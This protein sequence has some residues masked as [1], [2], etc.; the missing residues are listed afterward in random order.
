LY[1]SHSKLLLHC[2]ASSHHCKAP[3]PETEKLFVETFDTVL[4]HYFIYIK[5]LTVNPLKLPDIN[6]DTG[7]L[8][9]PGEYE[10]ADAN[11]GTPLLML[12][13]DHFAHVTPELKQNILAFYSELDETGKNSKVLKDVTKAIEELKT[14]KPK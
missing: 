8:A 6:Y 10:L 2:S 14:A 1:N 3:T 7:K 13:N 11:Y 12:K 9:A 5:N 4:S